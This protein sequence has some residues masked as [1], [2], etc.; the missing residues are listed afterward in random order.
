[1]GLKKLLKNL[2]QYL[3]KGKKKKKN[4]VTC[5]RIDKLLEQLKAK[6]KKLKKQLEKEK[7]TSKRKRIKTELKVISLQIKKGNKRRDELCD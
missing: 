2:N 1:M 7:N 3:D 4:Q 5:E 6:E